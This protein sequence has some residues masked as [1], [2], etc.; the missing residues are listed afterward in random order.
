[1]VV[2]KHL[3]NKEAE[4]FNFKLILMSAT[5]NIELFANYFSK[6]SISEIENKAVY[7]GIEEEMKRREDE[8]K[9]KLALAWGPCKNED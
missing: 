8:R 7:V 2:L 1:L 3:L 9:E 5:F 6:L 4:G